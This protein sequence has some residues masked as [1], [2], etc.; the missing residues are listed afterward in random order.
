MINRRISLISFFFFLFSFFLLNSADIPYKQ[1]KVR[2][3][4]GGRNMAE[5]SEIDEK[6]ALAEIHRMSQILGDIP[7]LLMPR[8][9]SRLH[10]MYYGVPLTEDRLY[11]LTKISLESISRG[12]TVGIVLYRASLLPD[13]FTYKATKRACG[14]FIKETKQ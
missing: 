2:A 7:L 14:E 8:T 9:S 11:K 3:K 6:Y 12:D 5:T 4:G 10:N 13:C 1:G